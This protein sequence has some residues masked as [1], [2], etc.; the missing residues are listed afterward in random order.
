MRHRLDHPDVRKIRDMLGD[1]LGIRTLK[2]Q[3]SQC[4]VW[5]HLEGS[6]GVV[7]AIEGNASTSLRIALG[8]L[9]PPRG[10]VHYSNDIVHGTLRRHS[11]F[12]RTHDAGQYWTSDTQRALQSRGVTP[13]SY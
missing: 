5:M 1:A 9:Y 4:I 13:F 3:A 12:V 7:T 8:E 11:P 6:Q 2:G 10:V